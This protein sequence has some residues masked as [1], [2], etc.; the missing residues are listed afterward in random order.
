MPSRRAK[1]H[2]THTRSYVRTPVHVHTCKRTPTHARTRPH[3]RRC[4]HPPADELVVGQPTR[5]AAPS[6]APHP[7]LARTILA[8]YCVAPPALILTSIEVL[9]QIKHR[10]PA[11]W[12]G[13]RHRRFSVHV[14]VLLVPWYTWTYTCT[15]TLVRTHVPCYPGTYHIMVRTNG[16][17]VLF[18]V[19]GTN[20]TRVPMGTR[21]PV[22]GT[23]V[24]LVLQYIPVTTYTHAHFDPF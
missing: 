8:R 14:Y 15:Q 10:R 19:Y 2:P 17:R 4:A 18:I 24:P 5:S 3:T 12:V 20:G 21:V 13:R 16:T 7:R 11:V 1:P 22:P 23:R 6:L 9:F